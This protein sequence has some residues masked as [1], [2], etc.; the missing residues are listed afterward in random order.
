M[1]L[2]EL[3]HAGARRTWGSGPADCGRGDTAS[4]SSAAQPSSGRGHRERRCSPRVKKHVTRLVVDVGNR[5]SA[6]REAALDAER[7]FPV[8]EALRSTRPRQGGRRVSGRHRTRG[9]GGSE[10]SRALEGLL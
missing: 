5:A 7:A 3:L 9:E 10:Y 1:R 4:R 8:V 6:W 2:V